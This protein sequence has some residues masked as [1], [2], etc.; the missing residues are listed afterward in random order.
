MGNP[1]FENFLLQ[2]SLL[3]YICTV[4][5]KLQPLRNA[6]APD[7]PYSGGAKHPRSE[8]LRSCGLRSAV[9][10]SSAQYYAGHTILPYLHQVGGGAGQPCPGSAGDTPQHHRV[11]EGFHLP[12]VYL[13]LSSPTGE[14][15]HGV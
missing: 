4:L 12:C 11:K 9:W 10:N 5:R 2:G 1:L 3:Q 14:V 8:N 7:L 15:S 6:Y 13:L